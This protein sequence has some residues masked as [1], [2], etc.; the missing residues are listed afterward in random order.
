MVN[1]T[2]NSTQSDFNGTFYKDYAAVK[3]KV[4]PH[5]VSNVRRHLNSLGVVKVQLA[6]RR[7]VSYH[8]YGVT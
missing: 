2:E 3:Q 5:S 7:W 1:E 8:V 6:F 4:T